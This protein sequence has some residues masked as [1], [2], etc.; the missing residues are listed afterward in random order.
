MLG[1]A[2]S[3]SL[4]DELHTTHPSQKERRQTK[5]AFVWQVTIGLKV[6]P[7]KLFMWMV[8][9]TFKNSSFSRV[10]PGRLP[11]CRPSLVLLLQSVLPSLAT[12]GLKVV[13]NKLPM[14]MVMATFKNSSLH[15]EAPGQLPT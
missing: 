13:L 8:M 6:E 3:T 15:Q 2:L 11:T 1:C 12:I 7:S 4:M 5:W 14:W 9:V 10:N